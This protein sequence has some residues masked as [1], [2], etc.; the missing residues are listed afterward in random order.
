V[1]SAKKKRRGSRA[2]DEAL[3]EVAKEETTRLNAI[4]PVSLHRQVK[5]QAAKEGKSITDI[6]ITSL[7]AYLKKY[8]NE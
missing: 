3:S 5:L 1:L 4:V 2:K 6:L 8:S 7:E